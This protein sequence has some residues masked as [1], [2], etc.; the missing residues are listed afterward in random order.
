MSRKSAFSFTQFSNDN[1][2]SGL[3]WI[4]LHCVRALAF[5]MVF[6]ILWALIDVGY[7]LLVEL[8]AN[9]WRE[10]FLVDNIFELLG[11]FLAVLIAIE[12]FLNIIF[13]L[14]EDSVHVPLVLATALTAVARKVIVLDYQHISVEHIYATGALVLAVGISYWLVTKKN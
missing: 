14:K 9:S 3:N 10:I 6:V 7:H 5:M 13:Y 8:S 1:F 12:V 11:G 2:I 4:V